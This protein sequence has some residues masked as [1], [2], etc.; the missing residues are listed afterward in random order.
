MTCCHLQKQQPAVLIVCACV[1][2]HVPIEPQVESFWL[3]DTL[4]VPPVAAS[5][6]A[7]STCASAGHSRTSSIQGLPFAAVSGQEGL[8][9]DAGATADEAGSSTSGTSMLDP[10]AATLDVVQEGGYELAQSCNE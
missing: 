7:G 2:F 9:L 6:K 3:S 1:C 10:F 8:G 4:T 5:S